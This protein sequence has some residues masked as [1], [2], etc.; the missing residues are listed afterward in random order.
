MCARHAS[1]LPMGRPLINCDLGE[2]ESRALTAALLDLVDAANICCGVHAGS[3][4]KTRETLAMA[5]GRGCLIG[6]HPGWG[7]AGGRGETLPGIVAFRDLLAEQVGGFLAEASAAG[8]TVRYVKLHGNLYHAVERDSR[9][10]ATYLEFLQSLPQDLAVVA[11]SGG[12]FQE[13]ARAAG[14]EVWEEGFADRAYRADGSLVPR[15]QPGA[16]LDAVA[17]LARVRA[18]MKHGWFATVEGTG[19]ELNMDTI[20]VHGDSPDSQTLLAGMR[21][22]LSA[23]NS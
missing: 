4:A 2:N 21:E 18:W 12:V 8:G 19:M 11:L 1:F 15:S 14:L 6:A 16:V 3:L 17:A 10:A 22:L 23:N 20:C 9:Y 7:L 5:V 13:R